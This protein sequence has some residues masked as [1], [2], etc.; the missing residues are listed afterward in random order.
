MHNGSVLY[1]TCTGSE[2]VSLPVCPP[3]IARCKQLIC[4]PSYAMDRSTKVGQVI[5]VICV[6][7]H[8]ISNTG[9]INSCQIIIPQ[10]QVNR[11]HGESAQEVS[12]LQTL[13]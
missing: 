10:N 7:N 2:P 3:Q 12:T 13:L 11:K 5:R 9:D 8:P 6:L 4:D 1:S